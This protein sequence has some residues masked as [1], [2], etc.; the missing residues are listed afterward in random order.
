[1]VIQ[2]DERRKKELEIELELLKERIRE[3][4]NELGY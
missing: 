2:E 3:I 4:E 1:M